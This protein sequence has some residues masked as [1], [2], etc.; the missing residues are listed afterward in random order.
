MRT[1]KEGDSSGHCEAWGRTGGDV[2]EYAPGGQL[3]A[4]LSAAGEAV[5]EVRAFLVTLIE[6]AES[7][8]TV[9]WLSCCRW[10]L[11][12]VRTTLEQ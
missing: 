1:R 9:P 5:A 6:D 3:A 10:R 4:K 11:H 8:D 12:L 7:G 2:C